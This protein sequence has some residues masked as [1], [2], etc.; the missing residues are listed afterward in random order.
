MIQELSEINLEQLFIS[1]LVAIGLDVGDKT[2]GIAVSDI[3]MK[4][5]SGVTTLI[6]GKDDISRLMAILSPY[7]IGLI[8]VGWPIQMNGI[9]GEQCKKVQEFISELSLVVDVPIVKWDERFSTKVVDSVLIEANIS[10]K[11]RKRYV[12]KI[13]ATYI[14]QG[15]L[16]YFERRI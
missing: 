7:K 6:R 4:I 5:A 15:V 1:R 3:R 16:E 2:I 11:K 13:A 10:R 8:A 14:L 12:D 9:P